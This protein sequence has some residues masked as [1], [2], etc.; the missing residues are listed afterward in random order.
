MKDFLQ[1][2]DK[3]FATKVLD[4]FLF[5]AIIGVI[6]F[7]FYL[8]L[9]YAPKSKNNVVISKDKIGIG[10]APEDAEESKESPN[11]TVIQQV[12]KETVDPKVDILI[13]QIEALKHEVE[14]NRSEGSRIPLSQH[15]VFNL[16][17]N[18]IERGVDL[19]KDV[20]KSCSVEKL[21][22]NRVF[23]DIKF[24]VVYEGLKSWVEAMERFNDESD[25][26]DIRKELF[27]VIDRIYG[28]IDAYNHKAKITPIYFTGNK[29]L[30][31]VP[32]LYISKFDEWHKSHI[33][34]IL[35]QI[36]QVIYGDF[37][38]SWRLRVII[39]LE[40]LETSLK[41]TKGDAER[42]LSGLN[43]ELEVCIKSNLKQ[44]V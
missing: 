6:L 23:L 32:D 3:P 43:G 18:Y 28:W 33:D 22:V 39:I 4:S 29:Y 38:P 30:D 15:S 36:N 20:T 2:L 10:G 5:L 25:P 17:K 9:K 42:T 12:Q 14:H 31:G 27:G 13:Q 1:W 34:T 35:S 24:H 19:S 7:F 44:S 40:H 21:K 8:F 16:L 41:M 11:V 37:Y 26:E